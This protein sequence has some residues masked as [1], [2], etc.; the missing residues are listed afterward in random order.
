M[1][2]SRRSFIPNPRLILAIPGI[3]RIC[4]SPS[5]HLCVSDASNGL[6][7]LAGGYLGDRPIPRSGPVCIAARHASTAS[8]RFFRQLPALGLS[9]VP[10]APAA[11]QPGTKHR[12]AGNSQSRRMV[13]S[14]LRQRTLERILLDRLAA[15][16]PHRL[17]RPRSPAWCFAHGRGSVPDPAAAKVNA[18]TTEGNRGHRAS[19]RSVRFQGASRDGRSPQLARG[20]VVAVR[21]QRVRTSECGK[22]GR[23]NQRGNDN[24]APITQS[25]KPAR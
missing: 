19:S 8:R 4:P 10:A 3:S 25:P 1:R 24:S 21:G 11:A 18:T 13:Q 7:G 2:R 9:L 20:P 23:N 6:Q 17:G 22:C 14:Q 15:V 16:P 5:Q 12:F